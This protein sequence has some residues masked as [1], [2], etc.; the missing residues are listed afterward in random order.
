M[1]D[2]LG[3]LS[4]CTWVWDIHHVSSSSVWEN[5]IFFFPFPACCIVVQYVFFPNANQAKKGSNS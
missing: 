1:R 5:W 3:V 2:W 4:K